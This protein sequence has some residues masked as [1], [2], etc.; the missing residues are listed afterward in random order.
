MRH[1]VHEV[2][3]ENGAQGLFIHVPDA[4]VM[5]FEINFRAG[6]YL[7]DRS[8][9][10]T[11]HIMEHLLLGANEI[12]PKSRDFQAEFE[13]NGAYCN[14]ST[15]TYEITYEAEREDF[16]WDRISDLLQIAISKPLFLEE[17]FDAEVGNI[18]EELV[19]R[20]NNHFRHLSLA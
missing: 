8:K 10:E 2:T 7:T 1:T 12:I 4:S 9:S 15:G 5:S 3:L 16:E 6:E 20:S 14:A 13:K 11:P 19:G 17:E 18:R